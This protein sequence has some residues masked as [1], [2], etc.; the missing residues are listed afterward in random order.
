[1]LEVHELQAWYDKSPALHGVT[2]RLEAGEIV[3]LLGR[4]GAGR[5]ST[6]RSIM[7]QL[8]CSGSIRFRG[9]EILGKQSFEIAQLGIGYVP[10]SRDIFPSLT[11]RQNLQ[12]GIQGRHATGPWNMQTVFALFPSLQ[13][14]A[15]VRGGALSGGEQQMLSLGRSLMGNPAL[16]MVDEPTEGLA[17]QLVQQ[18][19]AMLQHIASQGVSIL[20]VEQKLSIALPLSQR[21]YVMGRGEIV[22]EGNA[23][24][25]A[26]AQE[27]RREWLEV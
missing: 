21:L 8:R 24:S 3:S 26:Q 16:L 6:L 25:L 22:Y 19:G 4:N 15:D 1:M 7:G 10:E 23:H 17:P 27:V 5:S 12:L 11:V 14:R 18:V 13:A 9:Q 20:L 2:L